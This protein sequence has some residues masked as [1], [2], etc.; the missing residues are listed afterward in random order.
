MFSE[1]F[2][3]WSE[4]CCV[5]LD[6]VGLAGV[7]PPR[8]PI[9]G[10]GQSHACRPDQPTS[11]VFTIASLRKHPS[12]DYRT[13][14]T[15]REREFRVVIELPSQVQAGAPGQELRHIP[16]LL[17]HFLRRMAVVLD[18]VVRMTKYTISITLAIIVCTYPL[19]M[20]AP[21]VRS[22]LAPMC[23][24][25][26]FSPLCPETGIIGPSP[27]PYL[28]RTPPWA[29]FPDLLNVECKTL[30]FLFDGV[31][32]GP[33]F[34]LEIKKAETATGEL[35]TL[36]RVSDL[37]GREPHRLSERVCEGHNVYHGWR[38]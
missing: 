3:G 7:I 32:E 2:R 27:L 5:Q 33:G 23:T 10:F 21:P 19:A 36:V 12:G 18:T 13:L 4:I 14:G 9:I 29:D 30:E 34:A 20:V 28:D 35:A 22:A 8:Q 24:I 37:N 25:P 26:I 6:C 31:V 11:D 38:V 1:E 17:M 16:T 15:R